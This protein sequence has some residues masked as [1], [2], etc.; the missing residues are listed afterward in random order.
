MFTYIDFTKLPGGCVAACDRLPN[1]PGVY[2]F[3][4]CLRVPL[5]A[6]ATEFAKSIN[7][8]VSQKAATVKDAKAGSLHRVTLDSWSDLS[9]AKK[10]TL[11]NLSNDPQ[12]RSYLASILETVS[13]MQSPLYVGKAEN[14]QKRIIQHLDP[15]SDLSTRLRE[16]G[17]YIPKTILA[18]CVVDN[19]LFEPT[20]DSLFLIEELVTRIC[21]PG[22]VCRVG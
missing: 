11:D 13:L 8:V 3:F 21:R 4:R 19:M 22:F 5:H 2:A 20:P 17:I 14:L 18:Y 1:L 16:V 9:P 12:F 15:M 10:L 6:D 7:A